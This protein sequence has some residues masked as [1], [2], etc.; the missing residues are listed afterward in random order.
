MLPDLF[1]DEVFRIE[2][3]RLWLRWPRLADAPRL[4]DAVS[5]REVAEMTAT[6]PHPLPAGEAARRIE[7]MREGNASGDSLV[8]AMTPKREP[9]RLIGVLGVHV[10]ADADRLDL[11]YLLAAPYH[12]RGLMSEAVLG[13]AAAVFTYSGYR[14]IRAASRIINP[15]SARVLDKCGFVPLGQGLRPA[16]ARG[17][18][19]E[20][21]C[22]ELRREDWR[23][24]RAWGRPAAQIGGEARVS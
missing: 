11:G 21:E 19:I 18:A 23:R 24:T 1:R 20:V 9:D 4:Q 2:T 12:G 3:R 17:G 13:L 8:L 22:F 15:A 6:W 10:A 16:A 7:Q 14:R 5:T